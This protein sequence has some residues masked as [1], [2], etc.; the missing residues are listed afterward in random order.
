MSS[1]I[2]N[3]EIIDLRYLAKAYATA[4]FTAT[5][6][7]FHTSLREPPPSVETKSGL[8]GSSVCF[9][10]ERRLAM[11]VT[12]FVALP[13]IRTEEGELKP[14][15]AKKCANADAVER[16]AYRLAAWNAGAVAFTRTEDPATGELSEATVLRTIGDVPID[17]LLAD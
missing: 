17:H 11:A 10:L 8:R 5:S 12:Y 16:E 2:R 13:F 4:D 7:A 14:G 15:V 3:I 9:V 1:S 6:K